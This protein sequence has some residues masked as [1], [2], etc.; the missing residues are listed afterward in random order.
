MLAWIENLMK[1]WSPN[2]FN[3]Q[4]EYLHNNEPKYFFRWIKDTEGSDQWDNRRRLET[5]AK[6]KVVASV[7]GAKFIP[8]LAALAV[9]PSVEWKEKVEFILFRFVVWPAAAGSHMVCTQQ[10]DRKASHS[11]SYKKDGDRSKGK[12]RRICLGGRISSIP[13]RAW[14]FT[15]VNLED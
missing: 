2:F 14:Y 1:S 15:S 10:L 4:S 8:F 6:A 12:G 9:F 7:W 3:I 11:A 13:C 5:K